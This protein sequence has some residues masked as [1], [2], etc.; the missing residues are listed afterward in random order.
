M[1]FSRLK[2]PIPLPDVQEEVFVRDLETSKERKV[3]EFRY[4]SNL[5]W[6]AD[7]ERLYFAGFGKATGVYR[8][9]VDGVFSR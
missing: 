3:A 4:T 2:A 7:S 6:S 9:R 5:I 8:V 1:Y